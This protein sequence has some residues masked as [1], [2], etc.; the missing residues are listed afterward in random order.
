M[1]QPVTDD[2]LSETNWQ[3]ERNLSKTRWLSTVARQP[4]I[5]DGGALFICACARV[6]ESQRALGG[7]QAQHN[8]HITQRTT[9]SG[10]LAAAAARPNSTHSRRENGGS[11]FSSGEKTERVRGGGAGG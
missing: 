10:T 3:Q 2:R 9:E 1:T 4:R 6:C 11:W 8:S 5:T 7:S